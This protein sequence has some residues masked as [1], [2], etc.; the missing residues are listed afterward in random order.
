MGNS[1]PTFRTRA[2]LLNQLGEQLIKNESIALLELIKNSYDADASFCLVEMKDLT[3]PDTGTITILDDG[4]GMDYD[5]ITNVWLEVGTNYK[6]QIKKSIKS[7]TLVFNRIPLGEKGIGRLGAHRLGHEIEVITRKD[8]CKECRLF[9]NWDKVNSS[10]YIEDL[11]VE[12]E[13]R[14]PVV[15]GNGHGTQI[16]I[17]RLRGQWTRA[18]ARECARS[19]TSLNS[20]FEDQ[21]SFRV[22]LMLPD[23]DWLD[24]L[25]RFSDIEQYKLFSF[26]AK[27]QGTEIVDFHYEFQPFPTMGKLKPR[28]ILFD[29]IKSKHLDRLSMD[30]TTDLDLEKEKIGPV[31][32]KGI[33]FDLDSKVLS[34]GVQDKKGLREYLAKNGGIRVFRD[35]LRVWD[36]GEPENDWLGMD[37]KRVNQP[38]FKLSNKLVLGA[39]YLDSTQSTGLVEKANREGFVTNVAY[40]TFKN[41]CVYV[42]EKIEF[43]RRE[44]KDLLRKQYGPTSKDEPVIT[45]IEEAKAIIEKYVQSETAKKEMNLYLDR[46]QEDYRRITGSL[47]KSAGAGLNLIVV[48]HQMQKILKNITAGL[49]KNS[50]I[51][52]IEVQVKTLSAL[53]EGYSILVKNSE[54]KN[55][56]LKGLINNSVF[57]V[58]F[59]LEA[60]KIALDPAYEA[61]TSG[62]DGICSESHVMNAIMNLFDNSI[63]WLGYARTPDPTIFIDIS[64]DLPG[65]TTVLFADNGPGFALPTEE[66]GQPFVSAK[67]GGMGIG[68]HLTNQIMQ[69]LNGRL[70]FPD[71]GDFDIPSQYANGAKIALAFKKGNK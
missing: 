26:E 18:T 16:T 57:N 46:I 24:G 17:R 30:G 10:A 63:W 7:H 23:S 13:E 47:I 6:D 20:P 38:T 39:V 64:Q 15:F 41:A 8:G 34:I 68:L 49:K 53:V 67:P 51:E 58:S 45:S 27:M 54:V 35:N 48:I 50:P 5:I 2:R 37:E 25:M 28:K 62:L 14:E 9:I 40:E 22:E 55:R 65:Y 4:S 19:V 66:L 59:R 31:L 11:P 29:H 69:S 1:H 60:H 42:I 33:I 71:I 44:D 32:M 56:N 61:R 12:I 3:N 43:F 52:Q 70:I 36:Y 21:G